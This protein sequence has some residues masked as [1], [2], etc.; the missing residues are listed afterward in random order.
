MSN[1]ITTIMPVKSS[2]KVTTT[3]AKITTPKSTTTRRKRTPKVTTTKRNVTRKV[4]TKKLKRPAKS[5][6][7][8]NHYVRDYQSRVKIHNYEFTLFL[9]DCKKGLQLADKSARSFYNF[10]ILRYKA[11][12]NI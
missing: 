1:K 4:S 11:H 2:A 9:Q 8:F 12:F 10:A 7:T 3:Q 6:L 5:V